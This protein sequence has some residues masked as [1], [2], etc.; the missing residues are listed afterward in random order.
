MNI[1]SKH[2]AAALAGALSLM[3][4]AATNANANYTGL[5]DGNPS[6][7]DIWAATHPEFGKVVHSRH[8]P[9]AG[10]RCLP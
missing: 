9:M 6:A 3:A 2:I 4:F 1:R 8:A 7:V 10:Y 5:A